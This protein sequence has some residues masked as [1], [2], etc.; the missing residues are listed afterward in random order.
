MITYHL[1]SEL[2]LHGNILLQTDT[3]NIT[4]DFLGNFKLLEEFLIHF[5]CLTQPGNHLARTRFTLT[6]LLPQFFRDKR[7]ERMKQFKQT[8]EAIDNH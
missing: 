7:H 8:F 5:E 4:D 2:F 6:Q 1:Q 3:A